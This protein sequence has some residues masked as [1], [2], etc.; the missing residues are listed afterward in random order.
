MLDFTLTYAHHLAVFALAGVL[1]MEVALLRP[2]LARTQL[3]LLGRI[4]MAYGGLAGLVIAVG[5]LRVIYGAAG[6]GYYLGNHFFWA[7]MAAFAVAGALSIPPTLAIVGWRR[8]ASA[9]PD[10]LP[11]DSA[12]RHSRRFVLAGA[13]VLALVPG[14]AAAITRLG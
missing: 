9:D 11:P 1:A 4:D 7:K 3:E 8:A 2:G 12:L 10:Y 14:L 5:I 13:V 6:P